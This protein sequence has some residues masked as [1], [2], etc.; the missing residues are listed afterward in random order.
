MKSIPIPR[1][2]TE[3][4][5]RKGRTAATD[6]AECLRQVAVGALREDIRSGDVTSA[7]FGP[8]ERGS[9]R[10]FA[11]QAGVLSGAGA[12]AVVFG[13]LDPKARVRMHMKDGQAFRPGD[14]IA[15]VEAKLSALFTGERTALNILQQM[16][17]IAT[18]TCQFVKALGADAR[19][20]IY[21]TRKTTP[22][23][24]VLEK[25]AVL[26]GG[27][28]NHRLALDDMA[29]LK[30]NH[31]DAAGGVAAAVERLRGRGFFK[32]RPKLPLCIE[33]RDEGEALAALA[34]GANIIMLDNMTPAE[35]RRAVARLRKASEISLMRMPQVEIS[36]GVNLGNVRIYRNLPIDR[37]SVGALTHSAPAVDI[38]MHIK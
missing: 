2:V 22:L 11:K 30:N 3:T 18:L 12:I 14:T 31:I 25:Q 32:R 29:M 21:D 4:L 27:G 33:A 9:A 8:R 13:K 34:A 26:H 35:I 17:G 19:M 28:R 16:S 7:I 20:G 23:L 37:I 24:R 6:Y 10:I 36:G 15:T 5:D 1:E 38:A